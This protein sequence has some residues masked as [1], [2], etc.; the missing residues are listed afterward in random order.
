[1]HDDSSGGPPVTASLTTGA[2]GTLYVTLVGPP[3]ERWEDGWV[4]VHRLDPVADGGGACPLP[5]AHRSFRSRRTEAMA[6]NSTVEKCVSLVAIKPPDS[7]SRR[8]VPRV[9]RWTP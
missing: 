1:M 5:P 2:G 8:S 3:T 6:G 7:S 9:N 4:E